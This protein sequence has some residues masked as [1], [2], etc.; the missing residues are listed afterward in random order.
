MTCA[1]GKGVDRGTPSRSC[2]NPVLV[3][4]HA[5]EQLVPWH[6]WATLEAISNTQHAAPVLKRER[7]RTKQKGKTTRA[8]VILDFAARVVHQDQHNVRHTC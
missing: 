8:A 5:M 1:T 3:V 7:H 6:R 2:C 4:H